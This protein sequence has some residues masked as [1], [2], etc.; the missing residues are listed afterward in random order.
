MKILVCGGRDFGNVNKG[1]AITKEEIEEH[2]K[3][4]AEYRYIIDSLRSICQGRK[5]ERVTIIEGGATG[6]DSVAA[7][8]ALMDGCAIEEYQAKWK[9]H[10]VSAGPIR[11]RRMIEEG[12]PDVVIAFP[13][14]K[15]T[16]NM[17][18]QA[19]AYKIPVEKFSGASLPHLMPD[20]Q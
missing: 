4:L 11:N 9:E 16:A 2:K 8:F 17:V 1:K 3:R 18:A 13:G 14:G 20:Q 19:K 7:D 12:K 10:G 5:L 6:V 15:G